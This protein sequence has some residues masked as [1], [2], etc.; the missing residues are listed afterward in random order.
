MVRM[1]RQCKEK[2]YATFVCKRHNSYVSLMG[3]DNASR[4]SQAQTAATQIQIIERLEDV[5]TFTCGHAVTIINDLNPQILPPSLDGVH[6]NNIRSY[7]NLCI[8]LTLMHSIF[9]QV[10]KDTFQLDMIGI[11]QWQVRLK[12]RSYRSPRQDTF[13]TKHGAMHNFNNVAPFFFQ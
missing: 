7:N 2:T 5:L 13:K 12:L 1:N 3:F 9:Y 11:D 6:I 4:D 8:T 10:I